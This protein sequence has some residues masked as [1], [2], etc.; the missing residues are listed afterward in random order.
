MERYNTGIVVTQVNLQSAAAPREVQEAFDDVIRAREDEQRLKNQAESYANGVV[1]EARGEAQRMLEEAS[2]YR[3]SVIARAEGEANRFSKLREEY[4][5]APEVTRERLYLETMQ[6]IMGNTSKVLITAE[7]GQNSLLY[8]PL[9]KMINSSKSSSYSGSSGNS[10]TSAQQE[11][12]PVTNL[13][14]QP[15]PRSRGGR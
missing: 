1:P 14:E 10:N 11:A 13:P 7:Q 15:D 5:K 3:E 9:D 6:Q 8:L 4:S 2:G 12:V